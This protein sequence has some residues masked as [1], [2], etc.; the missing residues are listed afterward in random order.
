MHYPGSHHVILGSCEGTACCEV[1][2]FVRDLDVHDLLAD[3]LHVRIDVDEKDT[4]ELSVNRKVLGVEVSL[5]V[6]EPKRLSY[7][8]TVG[9][10]T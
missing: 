5:R 4:D 1:D 10:P 2:P 9:A 3:G 6:L 8:Y 7:V